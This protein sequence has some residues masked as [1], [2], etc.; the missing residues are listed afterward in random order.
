MK[1]VHSRAP[2][3]TRFEGP[4]LGIDLGTT[5]SVAA[6]LE[7]DG[8]RPLSNSLGRTL[9]SSAVALGDGDDLLIGDA[10]LE[11]VHRRPGDGVVRFKPDMG[12][13]R[14]WRIGHRELGPVELSALV[15]R[16]MKALAEASLQTTV[17]DAVVTVPAWFQEPQRRATIEAGRLAGLQIRRVL[18]EPTAAALAHG[19]HTAHEARTIL[20]LDLGGGTFDV[21]ALSMFEGVVEVLASVG[22]THLGGEDFTD[23]LLEHVLAGAEPDPEARALLRAR[24]ELAK[25][26]L[27]REDAVDIPYAGGEIAV[28]R[29]TFEAL[30]APRLERVRHCV[31]E[32]L[33]Q[34]R[35]APKDID[36]VVLVGGAT[37][38][39]CIHELVK[40]IFGREP[41][42]GIDVDH[43]VACGAAVQ[44]A[45]LAKNDAVR[46]F[47]V[48]DVLPHSLG[49]A[50]VKF[51]DDTYLDDRFDPILPR[52]T[53]LPA[54]RRETY[55]TLHQ[56]QDT[57]HLDVYQGER[58]IASH[59]HHLGRLV[60]ERLP[61]SEE[62]DHRV[63]VEVRFSHDTNGLLEVEATVPSTGEVVSSVFERGADLS[64]ADRAQALAALA[65]LK[66]P[67]Q[68]QLPNRF[69]LERA[70]RLFE[71]L[72]HGS[73]RETLDHAL[74]RFEAAL[75]RE[76]VH[77]P[78]ARQAVI[79]TVEMLAKRLGIKL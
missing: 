8:P 46:D 21:T 34:G 13:K 22:D 39:P 59:N 54:S 64:E 78:K 26:S 66:I 47:V 38:M 79:E 45:L 33:M 71:M 32:A 1:L 58:R 44:A 63:P 16:E 6:V 18:N 15:L 68:E 72:P 9:V 11:R 23:A 14:T 35:L 77:A 20:V 74:S 73:E 48:T 31:T 42:A 24:C 5:H 49:V 30:N 43:I 62:E 2:G 69:A 53:T 17:T 67:P 27:S 51:V 28:R 29:D 75:V 60:V 10:A 76:D 55:L 7:T 65:A 3:P 40:A 41:R 25:R 56:K 70:R 4:L 36:E 12:S 19:L 37:R 57:L 61:T 52:T 50:Y